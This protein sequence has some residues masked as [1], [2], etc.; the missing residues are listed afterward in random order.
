MVGG[1]SGQVFLGAYFPAAEESAIDIGS[2]GLKVAEALEKAG[3]MGRFAVDFISVKEGDGW[4]RY[5]IEI[6]LRKVYFP[7]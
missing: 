5:A 1:E 6:N 2:Y 7:V 3:V 4:K